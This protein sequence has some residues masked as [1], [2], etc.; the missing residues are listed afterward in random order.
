MSKNKKG[1]SV[2]LT[3]WVV[4]AVAAVAVLTGFWIKK[5][6]DRKEAEAQPVIVTTTGGGG[7]GV[8]G[9]IER[10][11]NEGVQQ[12]EGTPDIVDGTGQ[13]T[14]EPDD[15]NTV[16]DGQEPD[17]ENTSTTGEPE[18]SG[19]TKNDETSGNGNTVSVDGIDPLKPIVA[20][21]FDDGPGIYTERI[22]ETL[23]K[24]GAHATFFM[25]G[26]CVKQYP[27]QVRAVNAA[28][29]EIGNHTMS[30]SDLKKLSA[31]KI[32]EEIDTN[33]KNINEILGN[34]DG[35][36][37]VRTPYGNYNDTVKENCEHPM[38][39]WTVDTLDWKTKNAQSVLD[40]VKRS[41]KDGNIILMH[42]IYLST[43]EA[44]ELVVPW[45]TEQGYQICSVSEMYAA[46]RETMKD[47][48]VYSYTYN[49]D[50]YKKNNGL[51]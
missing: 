44:V 6:I 49:V 42:D 9:V 8:A 34:A 37:V 28:G 24:Y 48:H 25:L 14:G 43:A 31:E 11:E 27:D 47:G 1:T 45:L 22:L 30:H 41:V 32:R 17:G 19:E 40:E 33:Q 5:D 16:T 2:L 4:T 46:R 23:T 39:M 15:G 29:C 13:Q 20:L 3:I 51:E 10:N 26:D 12:N 38:I 21:S 7:N 50:Q 18:N 35:K 36:Y